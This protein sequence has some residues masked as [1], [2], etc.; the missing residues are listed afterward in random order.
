[1][2]SAVYCSK[3]REREGK[4]SCRALLYRIAL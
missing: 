4:M 2:S 3:E 1:V